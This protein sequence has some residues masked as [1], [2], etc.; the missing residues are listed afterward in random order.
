MSELLY[1]VSVAAVVCSPDLPFLSSF[2]AAEDGRYS[3]MC[4]SQAVPHLKG[5]FELQTSV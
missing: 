1:T 2:Q 4:Q 5:I 3:K